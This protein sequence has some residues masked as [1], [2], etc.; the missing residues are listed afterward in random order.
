[1]RSQTVQER[2]KKVRMK[3]MEKDMKGKRAMKMRIPDKSRK[4]R[5]EAR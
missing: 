1:V 4:G 5:K 3:A 2:R